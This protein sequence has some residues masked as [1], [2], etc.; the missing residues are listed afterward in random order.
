[1]NET[2]YEPLPAYTQVDSSTQAA[3]EDQQTTMARRSNS[4][5]QR[6]LRIVFLALVVTLLMKGLAST[7]H[8]YMQPTPRIHPPHQPFQ[9]ETQVNSLGVD[10][11]PS[12]VALEAHIM[13]KCPD[14]KYCLEKLV[15][16]VMQRVHEK[17]NFT[18]SFIGRL[19]PNSDAV[20][21]MHGT[22]ECLGNMILLCAQKLYP[23][24]K[25]FLGYAYC[26]IS[27]YQSI[28]ERDLVE[29][30]ALEHG[31]E[32]GNI[33]KCISDDAGEGI[34]MLRDSFERSAENNV[35]KSCTVRVNGQI[36]CIRDGGEWKDCE[37]GSSVDD[38]V[39]DIEEAYNSGTS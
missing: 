28:P 26:L 12:N 9:W 29:G 34:G 11:S 35:T 37:G 16:P 3:A 18:L 32:F 4:R 20:T 38:L 6:V 13:S 5:S 22:G 39:K 10:S 7:F 30:C 33:N 27:N 19:D 21:C 14:A 23:N 2:K 25:I 36:R 8:R 24:P 17:V 31:I 1:M 15:V